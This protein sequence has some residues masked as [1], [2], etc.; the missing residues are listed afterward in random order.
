MDA[1]EIYSKRLNAKEV[2]LL[3]EMEIHFSSSWWTNQTFWRRSGTENTHLDSGTPNSRRESKE[4]S[5][6]MR[7]VSSSITSRLTSRCQWSDKWL[8]V[9]VRKLHIP[10]SRWTQSQTLFAKRRIIPYSTGYIDVT[11]TTHTNLD[12]KQESRI[13]DYW[14]IDGSRDLSDS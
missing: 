13:D 3:K 4:F 1:S 5:W 8:L 7:M 6:R 12:V 14:S 11:R 2:T 10:P 9:H